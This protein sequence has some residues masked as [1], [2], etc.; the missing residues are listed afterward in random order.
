MTSKFYTR[1]GLFSAILCLSAAWGPI[2]LIP[3]SQAQSARAQN[4]AQSSLPDLSPEQ[5]VKDVKITFDNRAG[6][7]EYSAPTFDPFESRS[8]IA[9]S[10]NLRTVTQAVSID[11]QNLQDG[12]ILDLAFYYNQIG[13][14][15]HA[16]RGFE[17]VAFLSGSQADTIFYDTRALEC[18]TDVE[19]T[20]FDQSFHLNSGFFHPYGHYYGHRRFGHSSFGRHRGF[21][22]GFRRGFRNNRFGSRGFGH[23]RFGG[24]RR[25]HNRFGIGQGRGFRGNRG[26]NRDARRFD[27]FDNDRSEGR[28]ARGGRISRSEAKR[29]NGRVIGEPIKNNRF[30]NN[31]S[32]IRQDNRARAR[33]NRNIERRNNRRDNAQV[34]EQNNEASRRNT[35]T[36]NSNLRSRGRAATQPTRQQTRQRPQPQ[37]R[38]QSQNNQA[39]QPVQS[40]PSQNTQPRSQQTQRPA[41]SEQRSNNR[42]ANRANENRSRSNETR[43]NNSRANETRSNNRT[44]TRAS[45]RRA[46]PR[47][48]QK[49]SAPIRRNQI[50]KPK[51]LN[52]FPND[53]R[54]HDGRG[55][56]TSVR[57]DCTREESLSVHIPAERLEAA[58]FDGLTVLAFDRQGQE[59][60]IFIPANYIEGL[61]LAT[62]GQ[63]DGSL[64]RL[65]GRPPLSTSQG[66]QPDF[67]QDPNQGRK[68]S[69]EPNQRPQQSA[70]SQITPNGLIAS[71]P[72]GTI[73]QASDGSCLLM[74]N[75]KSEPAIGSYPQP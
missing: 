20:V 10:A 66:S 74:P 64:M 17:K 45:S 62:S 36:P 50:I 68:Q 22:R 19:R 31:R 8:D 42:N 58:R 38:R 51:A 70:P 75:A 30:R 1:A 14:N 40:Q 67:G 26:R 55:V 24:W 18:A 4:G 33:A 28:N 41:R 60:P 71:C 21:N 69:F 65:E 54:R 13:D 39:T 9:G 29:R 48:G 63:Y 49:R 15:P 2:E 6:T 3:E 37:N 32:N 16:D 35:I 61:R 7:Q 23:D 53:F 44:R 27:N 43:S 34:I 56:I 72:A 52:F 73:Y 11:G 12:A 5:I 47:R 46:L 57:T 59:L 25:G